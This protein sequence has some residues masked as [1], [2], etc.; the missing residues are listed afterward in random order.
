MLILF[1]KISEYYFVLF[2]FLF[3]AAQ[4]LPRQIMKYFK[5]NLP[6]IFEKVIV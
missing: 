6:S 1:P 2:V 3:T 4:G 5:C